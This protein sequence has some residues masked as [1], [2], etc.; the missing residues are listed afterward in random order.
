MHI[1][2]GC[3]ARENVCWQVLQYNLMYR[4][5]HKLIPIRHRE[6]R[7]AGKFTRSWT[8]DA[9]G[10]YYDKLDGKPFSTEFSHAR[11]AAIP[12]AREMGLTDWCMFVDCD[13]LFLH[14]P[15]EMLVYTDGRAAISCVQYNWREPEGLKMDGMM[16]LFYHRKLWSSMFL[17]RPTHPAHEVMTWDRINFATGAAMHAFDWVTDKEVLEIPKEWNWIP[18]YTD[19]DIK[20]KAVHFSFGGP[21]MTGFENV[22]Y[23]NDWRKEYQETLI[24]MVEDDMALDPVLV[25][26]GKM[27]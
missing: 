1:F 10:Q 15:K 24:A 9:K 14:D 19:R 20:P 6:L 25:A 22:P 27:M 23:A 21:W 13:F 16:Q 3:D 4:W 17:F 2:V 5:G 11:F 7:D 18:E 26:T 8:I 12:L